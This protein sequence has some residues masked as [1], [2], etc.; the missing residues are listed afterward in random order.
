[1][2]SAFNARHSRIDRSLA[3][4]RKTVNIIRSF[5]AVSSESIAD[6][7]Q[8]ERLTMY[9]PAAVS[10]M[11]NL[12]PSTLRRLAGQFADLLSETARIA[13]K[14]R[15][16]TDDDV[17]LLKRISQYTR[18]KKTPE[19]IRKLLTIVEPEPEKSNALA[20]LP[21][22]LAEFETLRQHLADVESKLTASQ[23]RHDQASAELLETRE[24]LERLETWL[25]LPWWKRFS[26]R[27]D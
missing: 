8:Y 2:V 20:L 14:K 3:P 9:N 15:K 16:Y 4:D 6:I 27:P 26:G 11:L 23:E 12:P 21:S 22:V 18:Q 5:R 24:R 17:L 1:M 13:G 7:R 19:E 25:K 10:E